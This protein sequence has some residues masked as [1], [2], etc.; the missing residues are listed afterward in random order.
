MEHKVVNRRASWQLCGELSEHRKRRSE[1]ATYEVIKKFK[2]QLVAVMVKV[3][4]ML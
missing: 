3:R 4:D 1:E 2:W